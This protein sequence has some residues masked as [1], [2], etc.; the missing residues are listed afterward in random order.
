MTQ[1]GVTQYKLDW[2]YQRCDY[3]DLIVEINSW[4]TR[5][6][7]LGGIGQSVERY[8]GIG[9]GNVSR[10]INATEFLV[11]GTKTGHIRI[12]QAEH[13]CKIIQCDIQNNFV[14]AEGPIAPSSESMTHHMIYHLVPSAMCVIH[15]HSPALWKAAPKLFIPVT[16]PSVGYGTP[17][18]AEAIKNS[19]QAHDSDIVAMGGHQDGVIGWS[20]DANLLGSKL[21]KLLEKVR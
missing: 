13:Y 20:S 5:F 4:R 17:A 10:R 21:T 11:S 15:I 2:H 12:L 8:D 6:F 7:D 18:M 9:F 3:A 1:E 14:K 16:P 19:I